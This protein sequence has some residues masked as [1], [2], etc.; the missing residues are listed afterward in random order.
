[1]VRLD[2]LCLKSLAD[3][4]EACVGKVDRNWVNGAVLKFPAG[5]RLCQELTVKIET[6]GKSL[7]LGQTAGL[8][9]K[10]VKDNMELCTV[11]P[12]DAFYPVHSKETWRL[13]DPEESNNCKERSASSYCVHW[14]NAVLTI[15]IGL[16]KDALP[17]KGSYIYD[18]ATEVFGTSELSAWPIEHVKALIRAPKMRA[19]AEEARRAGNW[20]EATYLWSKV[21]DESADEATSD[22]FANLARA[23]RKN[24]D[25]DA[26]TGAVERGLSKDPNS[27][28]L[29]QERA[30]I[31]MALRDWPAA[32]ESWQAM[33]VDGFDGKGTSDV[34]ASLARA[35]RKNRD[36]DAAVKAVERGIS[37][38]PSN[39][40]LARERAEIAVAQR[41]WPVAVASCRTIL[42]DFPQEVGARD[43]ARMIR[44]LQG[45]GEIGE[46]HAIGREAVLLYPDEA[47]TVLK[48][49][50]S[51]NSQK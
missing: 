34:L 30:E 48:P 37:K 51:G 14:W 11:L 35:H 6:L 44:A 22:D 33:L 32:V 18:K 24:G 13:L 2:V 25:F 27:F 9:T 15:A 40:R 4:P 43:Y 39:L 42:E 16:S 46:A 20:R 45:K 17:P 23:H 31:A 36:F 21:A 5:H 38:D 19:Q 7:A 12:T 29:A 1:M 47:S 3:L 10:A 8:M 28:R 41:D 49:L 26:A 50:L